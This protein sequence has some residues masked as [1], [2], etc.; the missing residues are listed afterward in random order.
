VA[1]VVVTPQQFMMVNF[2]AGRIA[3][4]VGELADR[5]G[6][7]ADL[8]IRL[9]IDEGSPLGRSSLES[10]DPVV[11][12]IEGGAL[13]D[14]ARLRQLSSQRTV[15]VVGRLLCRAL[16]RR[17]PRFGDAP[18]ES[19]LSLQQQTAWDTYALG[20]LSRL[21]YEAQRPRR[22]YHFR[23]RHGFSDVADRVFD[24]LWSAEHLTFA[25]LDGACEET[26]EEREAFAS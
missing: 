2:D 26:R 13:E 12:K 24:R 18:A 19:E 23:N 25:D 3:A 22:L 4:D 16:D 17:D 21:G 1:T 10:L 7:P 20:R 8:E 11:M 6:A 5:L 14:P 15:D 9:E